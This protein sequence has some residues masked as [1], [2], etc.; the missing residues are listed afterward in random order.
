MMKCIKSLIVDKDMN[1]KIRCNWA[2]KNEL[3]IDYHDKKWGTPTYNDNKLFEYLIL[4][5]MQAGLSWL[6]I[7]KKRENYRK[8]YDDFNLWVQQ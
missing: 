6:T 5:G 3:Y 2:S 1:D 7:L 8:A 4:E